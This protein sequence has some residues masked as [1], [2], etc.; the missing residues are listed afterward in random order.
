MRRGKRFLLGSKTK[1][2]GL[3]KDCP[4]G[5]AYVGVLEKRLGGSSCR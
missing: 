4:A 5:M 1:A 3:D 2:M